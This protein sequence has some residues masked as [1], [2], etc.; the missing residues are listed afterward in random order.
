MVPVA[1]GSRRAG[2]VVLARCGFE[3]NR[4]FVGRDPP[5]GFVEHKETSD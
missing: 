2:G 5:S 1:V 3:V 4:Y